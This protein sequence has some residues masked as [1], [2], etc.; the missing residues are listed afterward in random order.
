VNVQIVDPVLDPDLPAATDRAAAVSRAPASLPVWGLAALAAIAIHAVCVALVITYMQNEDMDDDLGAPALE[1]GLELTAPRLELTDLPPGPVAE[2]SAASPPVVEQKAKAEE[3]DL[4]KAQPTETEDPDRLVTPD[5]SKRPK[6]DDPEI[7]AMVTMPS[8]EAV[9]SEATAPP[10]SE[11]AQESPRSTAPSQ[12]VGD[13][14]RRAI[15]TWERQLGAH[16]DKHKR[17]PAAQARRNAETLVS[18]T[19]DRIGH[20]LSAEIVRSSGNASFDE[21]A[22]AMLRRSDPVPPPPPRVADEGLTFTLPVIFRA[23]EAR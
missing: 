23:K 7:K 16:L 8:T 14:A 1:I 4:P 12:G 11:T 3:T 21:A 20:V 18:F 17:Y 22:L 5:A 6:E 13:S 9:A 10:T 19:L 2:D 15:V